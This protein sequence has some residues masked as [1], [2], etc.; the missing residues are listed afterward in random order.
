L[1]TTF[2]TLLIL[3]YFGIQFFVFAIVAYPQDDQPVNDV[4]L[5]DAL[6]LDIGT[7][8][9]NDLVIWSNKLGISS[10]GSIDDLRSKLY[11][12]YKIPP[13]IKN[14]SKKNGRSIIIQSAKELNYLTNTKIDQNYI[15]LKGE[16]LLEMIDSNTKT[17]H[18]IK[19]DKIVFNQSE[20]TISAFGN[21]DYE[22][23]KDGEVEYFYGDSLVFEIETWNGIFFEGVSEKNRLVVNK[24]LGTS[25]NIPFF[26]A[27]ENIYRGSGDRIELNKG[28]L[29]SSRGNDPYYHLN[30]QKIWVLAPGEWAIKYAT[31]YVG[32]IPV[33]YVP[34]FFLPGD[35]LILNPSIG[36]KNIEGYFINTTTYLIGAKSDSSDDT[37]SFLKNNSK[38]ETE[39]EKI[40][41]GLF[42][43]TTDKDLDISKWP[44][45]NGSFLKL[46]FDY[47]TRKGL[48]FGLDSEL[49]FDSTLK[50]INIFTALS[51]TKYLYQDMELSKNGDLYTPYRL[52]ETGNFVSD[53]QQS[54]L[55][56][57]ILPFRYALDI[58]FNIKNKWLK[59]RI[60]IPFYSD[61]KF[62]SDFL[63][64][65]E[66]LKWTELLNNK[67][68]DIDEEKDLPSLLWVINGAI[69]PSVSILTPYI[70]NLTINK[71]NLG[72]NW[73]SAVSN[74]PYNSLLSLNNYIPEELLSFYYPS[75]LLFP[76]TAGKISGTFFNTKSRKES[77]SPHKTDTQ[78]IELLKEPWTN[79]EHVDSKVDNNIITVPEYQDNIPLDISSASKIFSNSLKYSIVPSLSINSIFSTDIP[80][81]SENISFVSDYSILTSS[82]S[83]SLDYLFDI[84]DTNLKISN[85]SVFSIYY[86]EHFDPVKK[87]D[88]WDSYLL[89]DKN[90]TKYEFKDLLKIN[91]KP[92]IDSSVL[93]QSVFSYNLNTIL[94]KRYYESVSNSFKENYF[95]W[96]K[97]SVP[98]HS[99][100]LEL[101]YFDSINY[102]IFKLRTVLPPGNFE[103][104]PELIFNIGPFVT[105]I[106]T[107]FIYK[108]L[109]EEKYWEYKP[110][111]AY[112]KYKFLKK[113][114]LKETVLLDSQNPASNYSNTVLFIDKFESHLKVN[115]TLEV[116]IDNNE[117]KKASTDIQLWFL[118]F[119]FL[120]E[121][122][123]GYSFV[124]PTGW[125]PDSSSE[126]Q[127]SKA[128]A[129]I[130]YKY[131]PDPFWKNRINLSLDI[132]SAWTMDFQRYTDTAFT[133][134]LIFSL[135]IAE[136]LDLN[137]ESKSVNRASYRYLAGY[138]EKLDLTE[139]NLISDLFKS[140]NFFNKH[141][142]LES[143]FNI[144][145]LSFS[146]VHHLSDWDL[147][148]NYSG[149]P[150]L[151]T[152]SDNSKEYQM[153]SNFSVFVTWKP[154]PEIKQNI[155]YSDKT[156]SFK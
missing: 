49:K 34:F 152:N 68:K 18:K 61:T 69:T 136:F 121:D 108:N 21:I 39:K 99:A 64:R 31:L 7:S 110:Y 9:F 8:N 118:Q 155:D 6:V 123:I 24:D 17:S 54:Y 109:P 53:Y 115:Q 56:G 3:F 33:F 92:F 5:N 91:S 106:K 128:S 58:D 98:R 38:G 29:S 26:F 97:D 122:V 12:Y 25:E 40:R 113:D 42:L 65:Q 70:E 60:N 77:P 37:F 84:S 105:S 124:L 140:F 23:A 76:D 93:S 4:L 119:N 75:T 88:I 59:M 138:S 127:P 67:G 74:Q 27:G 150:E 120:M 96:D 20:K 107:E 146:A 131:D 47:Y 135:K 32:R 141:D 147:N 46:L 134:N 86:K 104:Y 132:H 114:Y 101:K 94:Y 151:I 22:I 44:Y 73:Q 82:I 116:N 35:K 139:L 90:A 36:Y 145:S 11:A 143:N 144:E 83:S 117:F 133:F 55:F 129:G 51:F 71:L 15:I 41:K 111:E 43:H 112:L 126:F 130:N 72:F 149:K 57:Q 48:F 85:S 153:Q 13:E 30:A 16:V 103:F 62:R 95:L 89:Q 80:R 142:R 125:I 137:F 79:T 66:G 19:A 14:D 100:S 78:D 50:Y 45:S 63:N 10:N 102:Q 148:V 28:R 2:N 154:V 52:D 156:I 87:D 81:K 1:K